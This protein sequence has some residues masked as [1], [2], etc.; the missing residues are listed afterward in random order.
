MGTRTHSIRPS[1]L[2]M[3]L[4]VGVVTNV[5]I[6]TELMGQ[7]APVLPTLSNLTVI[8]DGDAGF[9]DSKLLPVSIATAYKGDFRYIG[10]LKNDKLK[11]QAAIASWTFSVPAPG[12]YNVYAT[13]V[14]FSNNGREIQYTFTS[15]SNKVPTVVGKLELDQMSK[16]ADGTYDGANWKKLATVV[17]KGDTLQIS[18]TAGKPM[19]ILDGMAIQPAAVTASSSSS[20]PSSSSIHSDYLCNGIFQGTPCSSSSSSSSSSVAAN[21]IIL[22]SIIVKD[23]KATFQY[24]KNF[25]T[26]V[27]LLTPEKQLTHA[28]NFF[29]ANKGPITLSLSDMN[30]LFKVG[31]P[32]IFCHGNNYNICSGKVVV[33]QST[34]SSSSSSAPF[35][36]PLDTCAAG[37][38][39]KCNSMKK[40][41]CTNLTTLPCYACSDA[42]SSSSVQSSSSSSAISETGGY[43]CVGNFCGGPVFGCPMTQTQCALTCGQ[44]SSVSSSTSSTPSSSSIHS[45]YPCSGTFQ[46]TP[47]SSSSMS[48]PVSSTA[49]S[50]PLATLKLSVAV[51]AIGTSDT[52][53]QNQK[54]I[55]LLRFQTQA[56]E[57]DVLY[58]GAI[59][60]AQIGNPINLQNYTLWVDTDTDGIVDSILQT[61]VPSVN[62]LVR[63]NSLIG[64][65]YIVPINHNV[66]FEVHADV[67]SS[68]TTT[69][70]AIQLAFATGVSDYI[71]AKTPYAISNFVGIKTN[72]V[73]ALAN[74]CEINVV[75]VASKLWS[76]DPQ[77]SLFITRDEQPRSRQLLGGELNEEI[78]RLQFRA[79]NED[80][81]V[82]NLQFNS[83]GSLAESIDRL[84]LYKLGSTTPFAVAT[85]GGC[86]SD[87]V[88]ATNNGMPIAAFCTSIQAQQLV[89]LDGQNQIVTVRPRLK[90]DE[91]GAV[92]GQAIQIWVSKRVEAI[93]AR[94]MQSSNNLDANDGNS[95]N[96]G[97]VF[98]GTDTVEANKDM[99]G[100]M[101]RSV[102]SKFTSVTNA[103]PDADGT[104]VP[105]GVSGFGRFRFTAAS[106]TNSLNGINKAT[107][108]GVIFNVN[109]LNVVLDGSAFKFYNAADSSS[110]QAC[111]AYGLTGNKITGRA[112]GSLLIDCK[113]LK[114]SFVDSRVYSG[115]SV[116]F[117]LEG[118]ITNSKVGVNMSALQASFQNFTTI[119]NTSYGASTTKSH[120]NWIDEDVNKTDFKW[121][122]HGDTLIRSTS[123]QS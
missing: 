51:Q 106:N 111:T 10:G 92:S 93:R 62:G 66:I 45:D 82:T 9:A 52:A 112:S 88:L 115:D 97:E 94:G 113:D 55:T 60:E 84:E 85:T 121:I 5:M 37:G 96:S 27:H 77:G 56:A 12:S 3:G 30:L 21:T 79:Q 70:A 25:T 32:Y 8:D 4:L 110:K 59:F 33:I 22:K 6:D 43:C 64:G 26:C 44:S 42:P 11:A 20:A 101:S 100:P 108:S 46:G 114:N 36:C 2:A 47:C 71:T 16:P 90:S 76:I 68:T 39:E 75:T 119:G 58:T 48:F 81:D 63:F 95:L 78:L 28:K 107:L 34:A 122:E 29:C 38:K 69:F 23:G 87:S 98:I 86:G 74:G 65:G 117:V 31:N 53:V 50:T 18:T 61:G 1:I 13:W 35:A 19:T 67:V 40:P 7:V 123:Y 73:C 116:T 102:L 15:L 99:V 72:T 118:N 54:N 41:V 120:I 109:A 105:T 49:S 14:P 103:N 17:V 80:I 24:E 91:Q 57:S 89:V 83:S 104:N